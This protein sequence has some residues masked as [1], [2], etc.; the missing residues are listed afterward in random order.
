M[1]KKDLI[2]NIRNTENVFVNVVVHQDIVLDIKANK[3]DLLDQIG[4]QTE[5]TE[6]KV[7]LTEDKTE[8]FIG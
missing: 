8:L 1:N 6:F 5:G 3:K 4:M 7:Y 2:R